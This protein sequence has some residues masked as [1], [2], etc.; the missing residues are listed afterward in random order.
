MARGTTMV[1]DGAIRYGYGATRYATLFRDNNGSL[2]PDRVREPIKFKLK[3][4]NSR[5]GARSVQGFIYLTPR[6]ARR[7]PGTRAVRRG[8]GSGPPSKETWAPLFW[9][10]LTWRRGGGWT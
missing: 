10:A 2:P 6:L 1:R 9:P 8:G 4:N 5:S 3:F 7:R